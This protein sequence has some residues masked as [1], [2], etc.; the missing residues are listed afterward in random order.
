MSE[1][2]VLASGETVPERELRRLKW[3]RYLEKHPDYCEKQREYDRQWRKRNREKYNEWTRNYTTKR[4]ER[5][6]AGLR[7]QRQKWYRKKRENLSNSY[8]CQILRLPVRFVP[9]QF[10]EAKRIHIKL[11]RLLCQNRKI[12]PTCAINC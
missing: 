1:N 12:L 7:E 3:Q 11:K 9:E 8:I 2:A 6:L 5:D 10:F 4:K